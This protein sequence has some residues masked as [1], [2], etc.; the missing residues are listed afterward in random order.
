MYMIIMNLDHGKYV[1]R[2]KIKNLHN[3]INRYKYNS[4][5]WRDNKI[6]SL[7][8]NMIIIFYISTVDKNSFSC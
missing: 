3:R 8:K 7:S 2:D 4:K 5:L 6:L 1:I